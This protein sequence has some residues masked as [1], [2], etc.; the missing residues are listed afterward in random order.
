M[1]GTIEKTKVESGSHTT[2]RSP[3]AKVIPEGKHTHEFCDLSEERM[4]FSMRQGYTIVLGQH[5]L[6]KFFGKMAAL[7]TQD[8]TGPG[9]MQ[10]KKG[11]WYSPYGKEFRETLRDEYRRGVTRLQLDKKMDF[12]EVREV[13]E[14]PYYT[15][16][17][18]CEAVA[19]YIQG[20]SGKNLTSEEAEV[21]WIQ[22]WEEQQRDER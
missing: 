1:F 12:A 4:I 6:L 19:T 14:S 7:C 16:D 9:G 17:Q 15:I 21:R 10:F 3:E 18:F 22:T 2:P 20:V 13:Y 8:F 11:V 5:L